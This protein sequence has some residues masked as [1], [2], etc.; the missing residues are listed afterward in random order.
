MIV[1]DVVYHRSYGN[2]VPMD[3]PPQM[4]CPVC[5]KRSKGFSKVKL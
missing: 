1:G 2:G 5:M 4:W 3:H